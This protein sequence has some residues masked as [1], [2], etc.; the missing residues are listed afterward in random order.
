MPFHAHE[1]LA[2]EIERGAVDYSTVEI[3]GARWEDLDPL[4]FER[5]RRL[6]RE[7]GARA[8]ALL[9]RL[10]D[11][12]IAKALGMV[13]TNGAVTGIRAGALLLFG[14]ERALARFVPSH[15]A[16]FQVLRGT[17]VEVN[18][19]TRKPLLAVAEA[20]IER[21]RAR[22]VEEE[23]QLGLVRVAVPAWSET[24]FREALANALIHRDYTALGA[25]HAQWDEDRLEVSNPG[26]LPQGI[27]LDNL[28]VAPP[29]PRNPLLADAFKRAGIVER[30]GRGVNRIFEEQL[31]YGRPAPDYSRSTAA[32]VV[33][34]LPGGPADLALTRFVVERERAGTSVSLADLQ[35]L[36]ELMSERRITTSRAALLLQRGEAD[37]RTQ[38]ARMVETGLLE[39]RQA[40][41]L[42]GTLVERGDLDRTGE[43]RGTR[44]VLPG[45]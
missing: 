19:F 31:R 45:S 40:S 21:F 6:V 15:E 23:L 29:R 38:L 11:L 30:V 7:S 9:G 2:H 27:R 1:M 17:A 25:V 3:A 13:A 24:G 26:G 10:S 39:P 16:A 42:L 37:A 36:G 20:F 35:I 28:L 22:N 14:T 43:R 33:A 12:D 5:L 32:S 41:R 44:Y 34:S 18:A 8:D 4:E